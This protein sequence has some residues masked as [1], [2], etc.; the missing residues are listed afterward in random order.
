MNLWGVAVLELVCHPDRNKGPDHAP[1][2]RPYTQH[3]LKMI[4]N[5]LPVDSF[6][7]WPRSFVQ[8]FA[9][10]LVSLHIL[11]LFLHVVPLNLSMVS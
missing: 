1:F 10:L 3:S 11:K 2:P 5:N 8:H 7:M 4:N 9:P 6:K